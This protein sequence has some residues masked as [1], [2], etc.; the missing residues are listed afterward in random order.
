MKAFG[1]YRMHVQP[2]KVNKIVQLAASSQDMLSL[3]EQANKD[4]GVCAMKPQIWQDF[5]SQ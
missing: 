5:P 2:Y 1:S 3:L 4:L